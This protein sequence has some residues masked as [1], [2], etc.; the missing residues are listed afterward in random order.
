[1]LK[2]LTFDL[3][4]TDLKAQTHKK[5]FREI[6]HALADEAGLDPAVL[7]RL[8]IYKEKRQT[9]AIGQGVAILDLQS[10]RVSQPLLV[11]AVLDHTVDFSAP[12]EKPVDLVAAILSPLTDGAVHLQRISGV[13]RLLR[14]QALCQ[15][16][17]EA[18][19]RDTLRLLLMAP[20]KR[21]YAA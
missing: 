18:K 3:I 13:S 16:L 12:D 8:F 17:R 6:A 15:S 5:C 19:D 20:D 9:S 7:T 1:M 11:L 2:N 14:D 10:V 4:L 21:L